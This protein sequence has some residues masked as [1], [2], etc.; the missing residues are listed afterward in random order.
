VIPIPRKLTGHIEKRSDSSLLIVI[1][2]KPK[3]TFISVKT[4]DEREAIK[5]MYRVIDEMER[6]TYI[7]PSD[8]TLSEYLDK[9]LDFMKPNLA[10]LTYI[11]YKG[12]IEN[13]FKP[14]MGDIQIS[15][16]RPL[17]IQ[18]HYQLLM[19]TGKGKPN[20][21]ST[22]ARKHH[23]LLHKA[24][25]QAV[26]WE[27]I[28]RNP[29]DMVDPPIISK[30]EAR[31]LRDDKAI[32]DM[33]DKAK[34]TIVYLVVLI[35]VTCGLR[36]GEI[37][38]LRW[39]DLNWDTRRFYVRHSLYRRIGEGL[40]L[41]TTKNGKARPVAIPD[42]V[43]KILKHE[44]L[45]RYGIEKENDDLHLYG[46]DYICAHEDG[47]PLDPHYVSINFDKLGAPITFHG[48]RHSHDTMLFRHKVDP[49]LVADRAG[50]DVTLTQ[51]IYEHVLPDQQNE[52][53]K[54]VDKILFKTPKK[55]AKKRQ[56]KQDEQQNSNT[57]PD[58]PL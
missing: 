23:N 58:Q 38:A 12:Q 16:L 53:A 54:L 6:G 8:I 4:T 30:F 49:N 18:E 44:Y 27:L 2:T 39:Q 1:N 32:R 28:Q 55:M 15:D 40:Q 24:L 19:S 31:V 50:R 52:V 36:R 7:Q 21:S 26:K 48:L 34:E 22:S 20:L 41:K 17:R 14:D 5:E 56:E 10:Y 3:R 13:Y 47:R 45:T 33:L 46:D 35:A 25:K 51:E 9:W 42:S 57:L 11:K 37:C 29:T 43:L